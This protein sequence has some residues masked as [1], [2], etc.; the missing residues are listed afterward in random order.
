[1]KT[2]D[3]VYF[4]QQAGILQALADT[5]RSLAS[6]VDQVVE[7]IAEAC[8]GDLRRIERKAEDMK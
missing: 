6:Q 2:D 3:A 8:D 1:M 4:L 5:L 7:A